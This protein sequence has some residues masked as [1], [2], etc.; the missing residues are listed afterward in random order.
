MG[1]DLRTIAFVGVGRHGQRLLDI[2]RGLDIE[3]RIVLVDKNESVLRERMAEYRGALVEAYQDKDIPSI[4]GTVDL[5]VLATPTADRAAPVLGMVAK[6]CRSFIIEKAFANSARELD[7][8]AASFR[9]N[10][11]RAYGGLVHRRM[12]FWR[13]IKARLRPG[14][15]SIVLQANLGAVGL[16]TDGIHLIDLFAFLTDAE[17]LSVEAAGRYPESI[18]SPRGNEYRDYGGNVTFRAG[19]TESFFNLA[20]NPSHNAFGTLT[21]VAENMIVI[22]ADIYSHVMIAE[23]DGTARSNPVYHY[24]RGWTNWK[25]VPIDDRFAYFNLYGA[26]MRALIRPSDGDEELLPSF[27]DGLLAHTA[28]FDALDRLSVPSDRRLP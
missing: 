21:L 10:G 27:E 23:D 24:G 4:P 2:F 12:K 9:R 14:R 16:A 5:C 25:T 3:A 19:N 1:N 7:S 26:T 6:G 20:V 8:I 17:R 28:L 13:D 15:A 18:P 11:V 22:S